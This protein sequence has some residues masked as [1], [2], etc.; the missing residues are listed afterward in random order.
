MPAFRFI[1]D[2]RHSGEGPEKI[3]LFGLT[4]GR[5]TATEVL[6]ATAARKL[7]ANPHF[8]KTE[9]GAKTECVAQPPAATRR[10]ARKTRR[11]GEASAP[12]SA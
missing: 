4:F 11:K 1:G 12:A 10:K 8:A 6:D 7:A 5:T 9:G 2:P 3:T